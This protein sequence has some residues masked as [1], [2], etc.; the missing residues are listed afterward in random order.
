M[1]TEIALDTFKTV[2][3]NNLSSMLVTLQMEAESSIVT[4]S[5]QEF[6]IGE[7]VP[8]V[9]TTYPCIFL[10]SPNS[11]NSNDHQGFQNRSITLNIVSWVI[12]NDLENLHRFLIRYTDSVSRLYRDETKWANSGFHNPLLGESNNSDLYTSD[13]GYAQGCYVQGT[14]DY[15][16]S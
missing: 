12:D 9:L 14:I 6:K 10:F 16:L 11:N 5:P 4:P 8:D 3:E 13:I 1:N 7:Y 2:L 15:I